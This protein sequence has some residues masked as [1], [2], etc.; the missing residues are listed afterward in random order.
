MLH[1]PIKLEL[2][3]GRSDAICRKCRGNFSKGEKR[4]VTSIL[5]PTI[6]P[7][8]YHTKCFL[9]SNGTVISRLFWILIKETN[10]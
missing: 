5:D 8:H 7:D 9:E 3:L 2:R 1:E 10:L 6:G 4:V